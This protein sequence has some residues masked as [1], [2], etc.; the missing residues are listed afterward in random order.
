VLQA[1]ALVKSKC[2]CGKESLCGG[3]GGDGLQESKM[4]VRTE[5]EPEQECCLLRAPDSPGLNSPR[6]NGGPLQQN[7]HSCASSHPPASESCH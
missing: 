6:A 1:V 7:H 4:G 5:E 2:V 3:A